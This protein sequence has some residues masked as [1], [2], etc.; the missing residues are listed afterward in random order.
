VQELPAR[1]NAGAVERRRAELTP[2]ELAVRR[3]NRRWMTVIAVPA[4]LLGAV[5]LVAAIEV[6]SGGSP[7]QPVTVPA[8]YRAISDSY[9]AYAVPATWSENDAF[10]DD[11]G[12][13][14]YQG[15][16]G[17]V[18]EHLGARTSPPVAG[19]TPPHHSPSSDKRRPSPTA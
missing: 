19:E 12:D 5:A 1:P 4:L 8:G 3:K 10:T 13:L 15:S 14:D 18:A 9:F 11:V 6:G 2:H 16:S 7:V 17:W